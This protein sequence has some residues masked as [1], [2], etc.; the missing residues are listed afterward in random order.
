[1][2][3]Q[4]EFELI[5]RAQ[6]AA[7]KNATND[8]RNDVAAL[9]NEVTK[10][11][12]AFDREAAA[13]NRD[14][15]ATRKNTDATNALMQA[16]AKARQDAL[17]AAGAV[18]A[19][20]PAQGT[21]RPRR[22]TTPQS[23]QPP[24]LPPSPPEPPSNDN[25]RRD[26]ARRQNLTYQVFDIGQGMTGGMPLP[27]IAAQQLPQV[28]QL[29]AG[30]GGMN[31][32][33]KDFR[34]M[35]GGA[36][37][38]ITPLTVGIAGLAGV[39]ATGAIAYNGYLQSTK[40]VE[41]AA[42]GLGRAVAGSRS[43]MEAAAQAGASAAGISVSSARSMEAQF[44][45]TGRIGSENFEALI[46]ISKD[47]GATMGITTDE[48]G[49][50]LSEMF[51]DPA[52]AADTLFQKYGLI[53][54]ATA[55]HASNLA[56]QNRQSEAQA[57]LLKA[58][59][60]QLADASEATTALGRAWEFAARNASNA[61]NWMGKTADRAISGPSLEEQLA[62]AEA[63]ERRRSA[64]YGVLDL[65][66]PFTTADLVSPARLAQ[67]REDKR[68]SDAETAERNRKAEE[69][70]RSRA[71]V[72]LY[73]ASPANARALQ[74]QK[75]R[76]DIA[77]MESAR[78]IEGIDAGQNE[79]AIEA[80]K[81]ALD[82]LINRQ[83]RSAEL[84]RLEIQISN[85]RN[86]LLRAELEA[87]RTRLQLSE[88]EVSAETIAI[89]AA[90]ARDRVIE[91]TIAAASSQASDM[92]VEVETRQR[93]NML[94]ASGAIT[95]ADA[96]RMLQEEITLRPLIAAAA[97][98]EGAEKD[99]LNKTIADLKGGYAALA[100][101]EKRASVMQFL[102]GQNDNLEQLRLEKALIG[103]NAA[104][105]ERAIALLD[106]EQKIR[107]M[108]LSASSREA[109]HI[110]ELALEQAKLTREIE[111]Q[112]EAWDAV[113]SAAESAIDGGIDK[114]I[115]GDFKGALESVAKDI[116]GMLSELAIKNPIKN[117]LLGSD[118]ATMSD[119]GGLGGLI[120]G[121]FGKRSSDPAAL[122]SG[123]LG[124]SVGT[125]SVS[126]ATV[127]INGGLG[128]GLFG[129][130]A[131]DNS[132][133][134]QFPGSISAYAKA[135]QS[136]ES[137]GNYSALGP[138]TASGDR[139]YGAYQVMGANIPSWTKQALGQSLTPQQFLGNSAAQDA[140]FEK[141][142]GG[143]V[144]KY[145]ASGAAQAWFGGPGSVGSGGAATDILGTSGTAY[146]QKFNAALGTATQSTNLAAQGLG[147]L[148]TG[149]DKLGNS[150]S[151]INLG[152]S[153]GGNL[154]GG[155]NWSSLFSP[156]FKETTTLGNF[157][158]FGFD[159]GG[160]TGPGEAKDVAGVVHADEFVFSKKAVQKIGVPKLDS[161]HKGLLRGFDT[162]GYTTGSVFPSVVGANS[163]VPSNVRNAP[164]INNYGSSEVQYEEQTDQHGN[165][166]P[167]ITIGRQMAAAIRQPGN[168][169]NRALQGEFGVKRQA[170][171][172]W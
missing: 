148:G 52:K 95:A 94:V 107:S 76:N 37:R 136:I 162:G 36:A 105:R 43:E 88:Q 145:G 16:E 79:A 53:D 72:P 118:N 12:A 113:R 66:N 150:L 30:Q 163:N 35:A 13:M 80:K 102:R 157:L 22:P 92:K 170:V 166:Q 168:P 144:S 91:E 142:F 70:A 124:Q 6:A 3:R 119:V 57:V 23:P 160:W 133:V 44:L 93:L 58:L 103:E 114:L 81:R 165:R 169:A 21:R 28:I 85:E 131:N 45:R 78:G 71:A 14:T 69:N 117:A 97:A 11:A 50:M 138:L 10:T 40:E 135:I 164:I 172:R 161:M 73:E 64:G 112:A 90:R 151:S 27:M 24:T 98:A 116:T 7:A 41:T 19:S 149:F 96:N 171:R 129:G 140:V 137:G 15:E 46:G 134:V 167:V 18:P 125:M 34:V 17:E 143:Y 109:G 89:E 62:E 51:A 120:S 49:A 9:G 153:A 108:G 99:R 132:N 5:F 63:A 25:A 82:A 141:I 101:E 59:P 155:F 127:M 122:V 65:L 159:S 32:A 56:A 1:M 39:L 31:E 20:S 152:G 77:A 54:A 121:L 60:D 84:D 68:R 110:R 86:P 128:G 48:A 67:L 154:F 75:L 115:D 83:Q 42:S 158:N 104:V 106:A 47:F 139:A 33:L 4:M 147:N 126:A 100:E 8:L 146:V 74:E 87:R 2:N 130:A 156:S 61:F 38:A 26:R 29:Y 55:R 123:A 111:K